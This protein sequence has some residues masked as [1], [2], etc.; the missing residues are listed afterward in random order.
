MCGLLFASRRRHTR[1][2]VVTGVQTCAL[3]IYDRP[4]V[5][6]PKR[7]ELTNVPE[8]IDVAADL[9]TLMGSPDI[10]SRRW[11]WEQYDSQVGADTVQTGG[12]AALVRIHG[13]NRA[14]AMTTDCTPRYRS[15]EH[16]SELQSLM[17]NSYAGFC[18][19]KNKQ[20]PTNIKS[21]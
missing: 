10:A 3:P 18:L 16:T 20:E 2:A 21:Q 12:D 14:L 9:K 17:R 6:T 8:T 1:S 19:K 4:H 13:T 7:P 11:I 5:P 15:E